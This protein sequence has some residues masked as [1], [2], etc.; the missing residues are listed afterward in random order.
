M[1]RSLTH[2]TL[3]LLLGACGTEVPTETS[4]SGADTTS[5]FAP[6][7]ALVEAVAL[8]ITEHAIDEV[9]MLRAHHEA[10]RAGVA[11]DTTAH[12]K[13]YE[14]ATAA[15]LASAFAYYAIVPAD[16]VTATSPAG[17]PLLVGVAPVAE[18][19]NALLVA[20]EKKGVEVLQVSVDAADPEQVM[21]VVFMS[22]DH[23]D[24]YDVRPGI[25]G[26]EARKLRRELKHMVH[27]GQVFL[28]A[29]D[30][31]ITYRMAV[32]DGNKVAY[33]DAEV[34]ELGVEAI[35]WRNKHHRK[36]KKGKA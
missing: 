25:K 7:T 19:E 33:T 23:V 36:A 16:T 14:T 11:M 22:K 32:T 4:T 24:E 2:L 12:T 3:A 1:D 31:N 21:H 28:Y 18:V 5:H 9:P 34:D 27:K 10:K 26:A 20:Y 15:D 35:V 17:M 6:E 30:S 29:E 13:P 8:M